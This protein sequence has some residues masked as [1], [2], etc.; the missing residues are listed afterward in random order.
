MTQTFHH[1][2]NS[3]QQGRMQPQAMPA[4]VGGR[5]L[6]RPLRNSVFGRRFLALDSRR[7]VDCMIWLFD[8]VSAEGM[9]SVWSF[10]RRAVDNR[11][12]HVLPVDA[13]GREKGGM[14][15]ACTPYV[16]NHDGIISLESL[17]VSRGGT[18]SIFETS[19]AVEQLL[20]ASVRCHAAG[21][22]HGSIDP[23]GVL[24]TTRGTLEISMYGLRESLKAQEVPADVRS[25]E[26]MSIGGIAWQMLTGLPKAHAPGDA[27]HVMVPQ[28]W[29]QWITKACDPISGFECPQEA[30][31]ALPNETCEPSES[32]FGAAR[33]LLGRLSSAVGATKLSSAASAPKENRTPKDS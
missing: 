8:G 20:D 5:A 11:K 10:L 15:W 28:V 9:P 14:C 26:V 23:N 12:P 18:L 2:N 32:R 24:V 31:K 29:R 19:R 16:G 6:I 25:A 4:Q 7:Q 13:A 33:T 1:M 17:R 3:D 21:V 27:E 22:V 30:L